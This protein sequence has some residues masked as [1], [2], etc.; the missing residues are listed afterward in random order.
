MNFKTFYIVIFVV[1]TSFYSC[2]S[3]P[4]VVCNTHEGLNSVLWVQR[5][6][7]YKALC[8]QIYSGAKFNLLEGLKTKTWSGSHNRKPGFENLPPAI[9]MDI[10]DT[11][12][13]GTTFQAEII[14]F[15]MKFTLENWFKWL[16]KGKAQPVPGAK[17]FID[18]VRK[19]GV[20][21]F[22]L[23]NRDE[24]F[25]KITIKNLKKHGISVDKQ[26][27]LIMYKQK[28]NWTKS[29]VNQRKFITENHRILLL[30]G[31]DLNDFFPSRELSSEKRDEKLNFY[32]N[33]WGKKW[34][35]IPN[36]YYGSWESA[37]LKGKTKSDLK[38]KYELLKTK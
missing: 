19:Q 29:K 7:E 34:I 8:I 14:K 4:N 13:S 38:T 2:K 15:K 16:N 21:I 11:I 3:T 25:R 32:K 36:P 1:L 18:F 33:Y 22:F 9:I 17:D 24:K 30:I 37:L 27:T 5:S 23:T 12:L 10:D 26:S 31:D 28:P 20:K 6:A 35:I